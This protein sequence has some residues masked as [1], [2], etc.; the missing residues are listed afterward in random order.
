[1]AKLQCSAVLITYVLPLA[2]TVDRFGRS[3]Y[4]KLGSS[5]INPAQAVLWISTVILLCITARSSLR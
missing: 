5:A 1:V 4:V 3:P 2:H